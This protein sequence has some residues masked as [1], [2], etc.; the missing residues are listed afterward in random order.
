MDINYDKPLMGL[1]MLCFF[2]FLKSNLALT[3]RGLKS[4][5]FSFSLH[6]HLG[7]LRVPGLGEGVRLNI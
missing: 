2:V 3:Q 7:G 6:L 4:S 5:L 1:K